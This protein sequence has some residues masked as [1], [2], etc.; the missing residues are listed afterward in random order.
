[1]KYSMTAERIYRWGGLALLLGGAGFLINT[2]YGDTV[3]EGFRPSHAG[4][5]L[6]G[7]IGWVGLI[8]GIL[9]V[10]GFTALYASTSRA[11]GATGFW[12]YVLSTVSGMVFGLGFGVIYTVAVPLMNTDDQKI[13]DLASGA[14]P[15][16]SI[17]LLF[18]GGTLLFVLGFALWGWAA[19][20]AQALP[21]WGSWGLIASAA[22]ALVF[23]VIRFAQPTF[24]PL[25]ADL[26]FILLFVLA[27]GLG[28]RLWTGERVT[29][30]RP[31]VGAMH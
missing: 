9:I 21:S 17:A 4:D 3:Y 10:Y 18:L 8:G 30:P 15:P 12:G 5:S 26:G 6:W 11:I 16:G 2:V 1:V 28:Y 29:S 25:L 31:A 7:L 27:I 14:Q 20:R 13:W 22:L 19:N 23:T 24:N